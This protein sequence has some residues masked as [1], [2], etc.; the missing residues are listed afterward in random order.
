[1]PFRKLE[2]APEDK[3]ACMDPEHDPPT[4]IC[5]DPGTYEYSCPRCRNKKIIKISRITF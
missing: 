2:D 3:T 1:M 5:L 4:G